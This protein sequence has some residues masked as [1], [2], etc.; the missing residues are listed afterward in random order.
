[1]KSTRLGC[2]RRDRNLTPHP[3]LQA[4]VSYRL[5][6]KPPDRISLDHTFSPPELR[7]KGVAGKVV[8][9]A[10]EHAIKNECVFASGTRAPGRS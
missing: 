6:G 10:F 9:A 4:Y 1:M 5:Y 2:N 3:P 7:G 8:K